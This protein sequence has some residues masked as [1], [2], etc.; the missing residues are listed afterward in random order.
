MPYCSAPITWYEIN[1]YFQNII[2]K[3]ILF[4]EDILTSGDIRLTKLPFDDESVD[5]VTS[6]LALHWVN[7]L[8]GAVLLIFASLALYRPIPFD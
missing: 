4:D 2:S 1:L 6:N 5:I 8:P 3:K 7:N